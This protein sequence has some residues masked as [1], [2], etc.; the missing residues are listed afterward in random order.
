MKPALFLIGGG[1]HCKACIDV[2]ELEGT[3]NISGIVDLQEKLHHKIL[4]YEIT[5]T[6]DDLTDLINEYDY[7]LITL[8]QIKYPTRRMALFEVMKK[9]KAKIPV[10]ISPLA[11][12]SKHAKIGR[13]TI[14]M[15]K[16]L[17]NAGAKVGENCIINTGAL[18]EHDAV[19]ENHCHVST[20]AVINGGVRVKRG[21]FIG[22]AA[23]SHEYI[24]IGENCI[25]G[26]GGVISKNIP[27]NSI[28]KSNYE[29]KITNRFS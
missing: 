25:I 12:V 17:V 13:G 28:I 8:G 9:L 19:I 15:H 21:T 23:V 29:K 16:A 1:G 24:E 7:F 6:D 5:A 14:I 10:I 26:A 3:Y 2:V 11:Y 4:G 20:S 22:S 18:I 27:S